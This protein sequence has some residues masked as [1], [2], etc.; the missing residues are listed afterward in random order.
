MAPTLARRETV[1]VRGRWLAAKQLC[2]TIA[3][4]ALAVV[5]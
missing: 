5:I 2:I 1:V 4:V 3:A